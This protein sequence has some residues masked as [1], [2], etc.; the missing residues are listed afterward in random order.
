MRVSRLRSIAVA[1]AIAAGATA[2]ATAPA[3]A[4]PIETMR[5]DCGYAGGTFWTT[6]EFGTITGFICQYRDN[7]GTTYRDMYSR[8]GDYYMTYRKVGGRW[9]VDYCCD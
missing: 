8:G 5:T 7:S 6:Y 9:A 4:M 3:N 2:L 1:V